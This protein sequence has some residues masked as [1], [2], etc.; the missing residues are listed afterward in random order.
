MVVKEVSIELDKE[1]E[2]ERAWKKEVRDKK[3][4]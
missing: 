3:N 1:R 2:S 4:Y